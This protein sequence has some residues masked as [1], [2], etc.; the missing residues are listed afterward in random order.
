MGL[1]GH[2][3]EVEF[4]LER[5][6]ELRGSG[7]RRERVTDIDEFVDGLDARRRIGR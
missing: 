2:I 3:L 5:I 7:S 6:V 1:I 4:K